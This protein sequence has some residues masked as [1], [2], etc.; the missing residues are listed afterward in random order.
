MHVH[1]KQQRTQVSTYLRRTE[2]LAIS[3][4]A[5]MMLAAEEVDGIAFVG[6][7]PQMLRDMGMKAGAISKVMQ[8]AD[9]LKGRTPAK[10]Q[11]ACMHA[12]THA[13]R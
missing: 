10:A 2:D 12:H 4:N 11:H 6:L 1:L 13:V 3:E 5:I 8:A 9:T 7:T